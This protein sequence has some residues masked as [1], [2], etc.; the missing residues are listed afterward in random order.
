[1]YWQAAA[2]YKQGTQ[3]DA[4]AAEAAAGAH[5]LQVGLQQQDE[6][7]QLLLRELHGVEHAPPVAWL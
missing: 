4:A 6:L 5:L 3:S 7:R 1:M 2:T